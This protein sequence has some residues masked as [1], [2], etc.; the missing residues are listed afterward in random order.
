MTVLESDFLPN[1]LI[2]N[3]SKGKSGTKKTILLMQVL[4][5]QPV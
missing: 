1:P 3:P 2:K 4:V 5:F